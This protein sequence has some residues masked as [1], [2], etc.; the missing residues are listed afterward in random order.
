MSS[1]RFSDS[2]YEKAYSARASRIKT[3]TRASFA[4]LLLKAMKARERKLAETM[5]QAQQSSTSRPPINIEE[6]LRLLERKVQF[7]SER[8]NLMDF[9]ESG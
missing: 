5:P 3:V 9:E 7:I 4:H 8:E 2:S 1:Q 6:R